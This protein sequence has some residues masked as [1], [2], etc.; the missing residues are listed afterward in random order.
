MPKG[1]NNII[2]AAIVLVFAA[3]AILLRYLDV[4]NRFYVIRATII[5]CAIVAWIP[6]QVDH[7][8]AASCCVWD[9]RGHGPGGAGPGGGVGQGPAVGV[10][11]KGRRERRRPA[12]SPGMAGPQAP[13]GE[14]L[15][16]C[17]DFR[18]GFSATAATWRL[19]CL[20]KSRSKRCWPPSGGRRSSPRSG[21]SWTTTGPAMPPS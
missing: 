20:S 14:S 4:P 16:A 15:S 5:T 11:A 17:Q 18:A 6:R 19:S 12:G 13:S 3:V 8:N 21:M 9:G 2:T 7:G 1:S 10:S